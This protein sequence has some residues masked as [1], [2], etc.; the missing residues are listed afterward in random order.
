MHSYA[1][2]FK[3]DCGIF[4]E[5]VLSDC[6]HYFSDAYSKTLTQKHNKTKPNFCDVAQLVERLP[7]KQ[8]AGGSNPPVAAMN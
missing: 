7:V 6:F 5:T 2:I 1:P 4:V 8:M 3:F